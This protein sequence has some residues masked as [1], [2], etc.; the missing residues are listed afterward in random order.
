MLHMTSEV[1]CLTSRLCCM[2]QESRTR[3]QK[4]HGQ[5]HRMRRSVYLGRVVE[6][7]RRNY[8]G[9]EIDPRIESVKGRENVTGKGKETVTAVIETGIVIGNVTGTETVIGTEVETEIE[10]ETERLKGTE[11]GIGRTGPGEKTGSV[12]GTVSETESGKGVVAVHVNIK[13]CL[14][15]ETGIV[16]GVVVGVVVQDGVVHAGNMPPCQNGFHG[17]TGVNTLSQKAPH[18]C[19]YLQSTWFRLLTITPTIIMKVQ[20]Q[21]I[22]TGFPRTCTIILLRD[23]RIIMRWPGHIREVNGNHVMAHGN[24]VKAHHLGHRDHCFIKLQSSLGNM[25]LVVKCLKNT[26]R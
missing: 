20:V 24:G 5:Y 15:R 25:A 26:M 11:I 21:E 22:C 16:V 4:I 6:V 14:V 18:C 9:N 10:V 7:W 1:S 13:R 3:R 19:Q 17:Q 23:L 2:V 12:R 8:L